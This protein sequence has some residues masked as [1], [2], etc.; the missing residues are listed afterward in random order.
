MVCVEVGD[1]VKR[2]IIV[3]IITIIILALGCIV[4]DINDD[5]DFHTSKTRE[6]SEY[7][8]EILDEVIRCLD[9]DDVETLYSL[10]SEDDKSKYNLERQIEEAMEV[11]DGKSVSCDEFS[12]GRGSIKVYYG[13]YSLKTVSV[14]YRK[15]E[16][17]SG[18]EYYIHVV[19]CLVNDAK[20]EN[21]GV[22][23]IHIMDENNI[24]TVIS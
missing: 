4:Y 9:E 1:I 22:R 13:Y 20:P 23:R 24:E 7:C 21:I 8:K 15:V 17:D 10:F 11:Y 19:I 16:T 2:I 5:V 18:K 12:C 6:E 3:F 14:K